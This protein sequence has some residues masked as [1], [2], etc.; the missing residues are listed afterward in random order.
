MI[1]SRSCW[2]IGRVPS[3]GSGRSRPRLSRLLWAWG[4]STF[5]S[6]ASSCSRIV[7][8]SLRRST[9]LSAAARAR[10]LV[11]WPM[12]TQGAAPVVD[13]FGLVGT[14]LEGRF[15]VER[16]IAE[17]GFGVVYYGTQTALDRPVAIK[18][19]KTPEAFDE[20]GARQ[21]HEKFAAEAKTIARINHPHI[22]DV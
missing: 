20:S 1:R 5:S 2:K 19:L 18:V 6:S 11:F 16:Q 15:R 14:T 4:E 7:I 3:R 22:V 21:F 9:T 12:M 8:G 13:R 17:G 10:V